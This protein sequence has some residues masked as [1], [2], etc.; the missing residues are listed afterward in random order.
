MAVKK[1]RSMGRALALC[2]L[3]GLTACAGA[4]SRP[5]EPEPLE[6][7]ESGKIT[8]VQYEQKT[9]ELLATTNKLNEMRGNVDEVKRRLQ[10]KWRGRERR[11][12]G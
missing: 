3:A 7:D 2:G 12:G 4:R 9:A 5:D 6:G 8:I 1:W 11:W 10:P